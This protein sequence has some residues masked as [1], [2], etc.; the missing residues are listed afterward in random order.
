MWGE[1]QAYQKELSSPATEDNDELGIQCSLPIPSGSL[2]VLICVWCYVVSLRGTP[3]PSTRGLVRKLVPPG[4]PRDTWL[5][6]S[7]RRRGDPFVRT[8]SE[9]LI[10]KPRPIRFTGH[11]LYLNKFP[12]S[13]TRHTPLIFVHY[14]PCHTFPLLARM[15]VPPGISFGRS[16]IITSS[17]D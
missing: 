14:L 17:A 13:R 7:G 6:S 11:H 12:S 10:R 8:V 15:S 16:C 1:G 9:Y 5:C 3:Q 4:I 2:G